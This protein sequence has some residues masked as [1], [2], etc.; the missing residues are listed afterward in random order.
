MPWHVGTS[1]TCPSSKPHAVIKDSD[2]TVE[3][4]HA[5]EE[6]AKAQVAALYA[7]E[8]KGMTE[9]ATTKPVGGQNL[10]ASAFLVVED[11][12]ETSTWHLPVKDASGKPDRTRMGAAWAALHEGYRGNKYEGPNKQQAISKLR[13]LYDQIGASPPG[14]K[15]L[16]DKVVDA[17]KSVLA[18]ES[19]PQPDS[20]LMLW[21]DTDTG[22]YKWLARYSNNLRDRDNP[23]EI[24]T[25]QAHRRFVEMV[26]NKEAP[27][28]ELW[29]WH[30]PGTRWGQAQWVAYDDSGD[31]GF[32]LAGGTVDK[33]KEAI[34]EA[35][36]ALSPDTVRLSHGMPISSIVRDEK[37]NTLITEYT[38]REISPLPE[39]WAANQ[40]TGFSILKEGKEM[41]IPTEKRQAL[42]EWGLS[43]EVLALVEQDS[44]EQAE[45]A[46]EA[47]LATKAETEPEATETETQEAP[48]APAPLTR[49]EVAEVLNPLANAVGALA[50]QVQA[51]SKEITTLK[52]AD[53]QKIAA[54]AADTPA[55]SLMD[56]LKFRA[57]GAPEAKEDGRSTLSKSGPAEKEAPVPVITG[58]PF[59]D[60]LATGRDTQITAG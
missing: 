45:E 29:L 32:T 2:G 39:A 55:A 10:P 25:A 34:A 6:Q 14:S 51:L 27:L 58:I 56:L 40:Y 31:V 4:C 1:D 47:G 16:L 35:I 28:P 15:S 59:V 48:V 13:K 3:G 26:D 43:P 42:Q 12:E 52:Q 7:S 33:G 30:T 57:V 9:K 60:A 18:P 53:E 46:K 20:G 24:L 11:A 19:E 54:K 44:A 38:T 23:P 17:V 22:Q 21:K 50:A 37:D 49:E 36:A 41:G 5:T 8:E